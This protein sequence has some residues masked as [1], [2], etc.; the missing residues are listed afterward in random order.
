MGYLL[1]SCVFID[2]MNGNPAIQNRI[3]NEGLENCYCCDIVL[4]ELFT[5]PYKSQNDCHLKQVEWLEKRFRQLPF[6]D[7][8]K[9]YARIR[10]FL[11]RQ[12]WK[13]DNMDMQIAS[14]AIDYDLTLV[15]S[16]LRNFDRIPGLKL[17][18]WE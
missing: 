3:A 16:N 14:I 17:E 5:G 2:L 6:K 4:A 1:D 12:G 11:E 18:V 8:Y 7:S 9:T 10:A 15:T 13:P